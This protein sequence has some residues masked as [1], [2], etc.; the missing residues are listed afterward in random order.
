MSAPLPIEASCTGTT[1]LSTPRSI[2]RF[3]S[4]SQPPSESPSSRAAR[5]RRC[6]S[7]ELKKELLE[8]GA[9]SFFAS[10]V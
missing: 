5:M 4:M 10:R 7:S 6:R 3:R 8:A 1:A 2:S 9:N